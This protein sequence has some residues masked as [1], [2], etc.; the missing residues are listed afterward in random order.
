MINN[1]KLITTLLLAL[2]YLLAEKE[3]ITEEDEKI[4]FKIHDHR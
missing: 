1:L 2:S 3:L 4:M